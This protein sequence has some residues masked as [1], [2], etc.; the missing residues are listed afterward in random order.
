MAWALATVRQPLLLCILEFVTTAETL[1]VNRS[2]IDKGIRRR[3]RIN[4]I[5]G[6]GGVAQIVVETATAGAMS[7]GVLWANLSGLFMENGAAQ[8]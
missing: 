4:D 7:C 2:R 8:L 6:P 3:F 1:A 5:F